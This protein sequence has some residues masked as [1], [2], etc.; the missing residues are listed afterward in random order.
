[1]ALSEFEIKKAEKLVKGFIDKHRP[2]VHIRNEV[3]IGY[4]IVNQSVEIFE[5]RPRWDNPKEKTETP[6]VKTTYVKADKAWKIYWQRSDL[7]W[8][9]YQPYPTAKYL[10]EVL[11]VV[12]ED[13]NACFW[14]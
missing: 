4:R 6:V 13:K 9:S 2:P 1:M 14:G 12:G 10:E 3:D 5:I 8:H 11:E 7:K